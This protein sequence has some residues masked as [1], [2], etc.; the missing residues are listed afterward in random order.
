[1]KRCLAALALSLSA[2]TPA[3]AQ[4]PV[5][6][7]YSTAAEALVRGAS[8]FCVAVY[9]MAIAHRRG[10]FTESEAQDLIWE[11]PGW[12]A[13]RNAPRSDF[14]DGDRDDLV[15]GEAVLQ[16]GVTGRV[17]VAASFSNNATCSILVRD[18]P[19]V[20]HDAIV[21][22]ESDPKYVRISTGHGPEAGI[23]MFGL[24][25]DGSSTF[26]FGITVFSPVTQTALQ[27][28]FDALASV[29]LIPKA[30]IESRRY[31]PPT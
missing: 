12:R 28:R 17:Y 14:F 16:P 11:V 25:Y 26:D 13:T 24:R 1:V 15:F 30:A 7:R 8:N 22:L 19:S 4:A 31:P 2:A 5:D 23:V 10:M 21:L 18:A 3:A 6:V 20:A 29:T 27:T 9:A